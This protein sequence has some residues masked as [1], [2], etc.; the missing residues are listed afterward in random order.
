MKEITKMLA[1]EF[2][3]SETHV[4]N[5]IDLIDEGNTIPFIARYRKEMHGTM[6]DTVL[7][8]LYDR[9]NYLRNL[10]ERKEEVMKAIESQDKLT[11]ELSIRINDAKTLAEVE[12]LYRPYKK[13]RRTRAI[14]AKERGLEPL[15]LILFKQDND[16]PDIEVLAIEYIDEDNGVN[17]VNEALMGASDIIAEITADSADIRQGLRAQFMKTGII[18]V[19]ASTDEDSVYSNYHEFKRSIATIQNHQILAINRGEKEGFL[20]VSVDIEREK[21]LKLIY[22]KVIRKG[23]SSSEFVLNAAEDG[24]DRLILPSLEREVRN[25]LTDVASEGAINNFSL[26]LK[27]LL[28]QP[29]IKGHITMGLDPGY[30]NG[31]KVAV[32]DETGKP[33]DTAVVY[34]TFGEKQKNESINTLKKLIKKYKVE[35]IAIGNG[36]ASRETEQMTSEL[37]AETKGVSYMIVNE[38]GASVYSASKLAAEEFPN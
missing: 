6:D 28:M 38:A 14:I 18:A 37:I 12:D 9:L 1:K 35:H 21:A 5:V 22:K 2:D 36:T 17:D 31:C 23:S 29:P 11:D 20:K 32:I 15:A 19:T 7:R 27:P 4:K 3:K 8:N 16:L 34:P 13:K 10:N 24:Y 26:N 33:L 25:T 30:R